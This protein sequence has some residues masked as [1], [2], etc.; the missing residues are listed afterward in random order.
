MDSKP[1]KKKRKYRGQPP[2]RWPEFIEAARKRIAA[3]VGWQKKFTPE[4]QIAEQIVIDG[5]GERFLKAARRGRPTQK[6]N[7][8]CEVLREVET[9]LDVKRRRPV[10]NTPNAIADA[11]V[12][13]L[14]HPDKG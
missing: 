8:R 3:G 4:R 6:Q 14:Q 1:E 11:P 2:A 13:E 7:L 12:L 9:M 10:R 5:E